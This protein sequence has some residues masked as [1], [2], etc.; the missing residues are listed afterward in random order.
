M[1]KILYLLLS[2]FII[3]TGC[4]SKPSAKT[5]APPVQGLDVEKIL[6]G[7]DLS[8]LSKIDN[9]ELPKFVIAIISDST[10]IDEADIDLAGFLQTEINNTGRVT[11]VDRNQMDRIIEEQKLQLSGIT[12]SVTAEI[13]EILGADYI[14]TAQIVSASSQK[15]DK[16]AYDALEI[17][18][19]LQINLINVSSGELYKSFKSDGK[20]SEKIITDADGNLITGA[21]DYANLYAEATQNALA[22][23]IPDFI[24]SF[25]AIGFVLRVDGNVFTTDLGNNVLAKSGQLV[26]FISQGS[27]I[28]HPLT[29]E[30]LNYEYEYYASG[31]ISE[32]QAKTS[33]V[34]IDD[35][36]LPPGN[37]IAVLID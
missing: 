34:T 4:Q 30:I 37:A 3:L 14:L 28:T 6:S 10:E 2:I 25:P 32:I 20:T 15:V 13:G 23:I 8:V 17:N 36:S 11:L 29:G 7:Y 9:N 22:S 12:D 27:P 16:V 31:S 26:A 18:I 24:D 5:N 35:E 33:V 1:K 21:V 19:V